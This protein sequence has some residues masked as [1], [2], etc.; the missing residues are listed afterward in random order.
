MIT[1]DFSF[2]A[3]AKQQL[4]RL[5]SDLFASLPDDPPSVAMIGWGVFYDNRGTAAGEGVVVSYYKDSE[6]PGISR[7]IAYE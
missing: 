6:V 1:A 4:A 7:G 5:K 3:A 2:S